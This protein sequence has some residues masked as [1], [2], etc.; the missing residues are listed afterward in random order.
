M[1]RLQPG[2]IDKIKE[3]RGAIEGLKPEVSPEASYHLQ[4]AMAQLLLAKIA[5]ESNELGNTIPLSNGI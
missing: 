3:L 2:P 1:K 4:A 5:E